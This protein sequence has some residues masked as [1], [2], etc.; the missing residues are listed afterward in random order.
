MTEPLSL[1]GVKNGRLRKLEG[2]QRE[3]PPR[4]RFTGSCC[5]PRRLQGNRRVRRQRRRQARIHFCVRSP[6]WHVGNGGRLAQPVGRYPGTSVMLT[7]LRAIF[8]R[9]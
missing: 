1:K 5:S 6:F 9:P 8:R 2:A 3:S 7:S 4:R